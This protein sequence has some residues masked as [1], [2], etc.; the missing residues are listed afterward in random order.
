MYYN[1]YEIK[2]LLISYSENTGVGFRA[3]L[4]V[5]LMSKEA[6]DLGKPLCS[7]KCVWGGKEAV[8]E[9]PVCL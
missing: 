4:R 8:G 3:N 5:N 2:T 9:M 6:G 1:L 7:S